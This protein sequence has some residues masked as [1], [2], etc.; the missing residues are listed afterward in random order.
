[1]SGYSLKQKQ[2]INL[3]PRLH[4]PINLKDEVHKAFKS[5]NSKEISRVT[6]LYYKH[7]ISKRKEKYSAKNKKN[8]EEAKKIFGIT[9]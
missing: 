5:G 9:D 2:M 6:R 3:L 8:Y 7:V 4:Q 1:M